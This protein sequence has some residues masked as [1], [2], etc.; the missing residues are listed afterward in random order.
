MEPPYE[1]SERV[2]ELWAEHVRDLEAMGIASTADRRLLAAL[3]EAEWLHEWASMKIAALG[4]PLQRSDAPGRFQISKLVLVQERA[5]RDILRISQEFGF[6]PASRTRV[7]VSHPLNTR[8]SPNA[9]RFGPRP[10]PF[11]G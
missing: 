6:S 5:T 8:T 9:S 2:A 3:C 4:S 10:N 7:D 1:M 11:A